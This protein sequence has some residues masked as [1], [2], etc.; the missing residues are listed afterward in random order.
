MSQLRF[1]LVKVF[2][3]DAMI[4]AALT[5][6]VDTGTTGQGQLLAAVTRKGDRGR[7]PL[8]G[9]A[10]GGFIDLVVPFEPLGDA[11]HS[12]TPSH[13]LTPSEGS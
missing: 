12:L 11:R 8:I 4:C 10:K 7:V 1:P 6:G 2:Y 13:R 3:M 9:P 5:G